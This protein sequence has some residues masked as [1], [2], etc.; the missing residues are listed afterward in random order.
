MWH[1]DAVAFEIARYGQIQGRPIKNTL[2][3]FGWSMPANPAST[4]SLD[5]MHLAAALLSEERTFLTFDKRQA[6]AAT[7]EGLLVKP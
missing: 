2:S 1:P 7:A 3:N 5:L 6:K 4:R